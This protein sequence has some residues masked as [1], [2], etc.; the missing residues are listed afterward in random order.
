MH[1]NLIFC[2]SSLNSENYLFEGQQ[3]PM[4]CNINAASKLNLIFR[5]DMSSQQA[6]PN[7]LQH[8]QLTDKI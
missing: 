2:L 6:K 4:S 8:L 5:D 7:V 3:K 1:T